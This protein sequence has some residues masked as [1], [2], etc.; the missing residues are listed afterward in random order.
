MKVIVAGIREYRVEYAIDV[1]DDPVWEGE[2]VTVDDYAENVVW[3]ADFKGELDKL[4]LVLRE[5]LGI[6]HVQ[7]ISH[8]EER[9]DIPNVC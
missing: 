4:N 9:H 5:D 3:D 7:A 6:D 1:P 8:W 2:S